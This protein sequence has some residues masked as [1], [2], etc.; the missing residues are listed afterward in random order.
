MTLEN[1]NLWQGGKRVTNIFREGTIWGKK[2]ALFQRPK[3]ESFQEVCFSY[4]D[5][6]KE[7][8]DDH[9]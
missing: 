7:V 6:A 3:N 8:K 1:A 2:G 9:Y 5:N 4:Q